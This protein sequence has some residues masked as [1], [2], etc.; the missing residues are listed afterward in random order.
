MTQSQQQVV[1]GSNPK[2]WKRPK[3]GGKEQNS[4]DDIAGT[5]HAV[6]S[7]VVEFRPGDRVAAFHRMN[8]PH[9][10]FAEYAIAPVTTT[11]HIPAKTTYE[12]AA[13][14]PLAAMTA[15]VGLFI[16][17]GLPE[18]YTQGREDGKGGPPT[19][20]LLVYGAASSVGAYAIQLAKHANIGPIIAVAGRGIPFVQSLLGSEDSVIDYR[21]GDDHVVSEIQVA[22]K[23]Q[24]LR[25][26]FDAVSEKGSYQ[27]ACKT[28]KK[29]GSKITLVLPGRK[30]DDIPASIEH[31]V[32]TVGDT[33][34]KQT[35]F[36]YAWF[37]LFTKGLREGW[38]KPHPTEVVPGGLAGVEK[39]LNDLMNGKNSAS[40]YVFRIADT[41]GISGSSL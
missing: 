31:N 1:A 35:D 4:G 40:K 28:M 41:P 39:G 19:G 32:T 37:R 29:E 9:G 2:D 14:I 11:F 33:Y 13:S 36:G 23:G 22:L 12:E 10:A 20:P 25:Y 30:Y 16:R 6:G 34:Q 24:E 27:N 18:P 15:A 38:L 26:T 21:K 3:I 8:T 7:E 17:L 5:V